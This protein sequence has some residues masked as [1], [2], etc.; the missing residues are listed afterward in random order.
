MKNRVTYNLDQEVI[1]EIQRVA[2]KQGVSASSLVN[3][4]MKAGLDT[5]RELMTALE[6]MS[7]D[8]LLEVLTAEGRRKKKK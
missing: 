1:D 2:E 3:T 8:R 5:Q 6:G 4:V 7:I